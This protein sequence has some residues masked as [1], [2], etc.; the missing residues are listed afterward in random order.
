VQGRRDVD[1][2]CSRLQELGA[3]PASPGAADAGGELS[4][5]D[6]FLAAVWTEIHLCHVCSRQKL[7]SDPRACAATAGGGGGGGGGR[8]ESELHRAVVCTLL[9]EYRFFPRYPA[10]ELTL[11]GRLLVSMRPV[12][13]GY[14]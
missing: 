7:F 6:A 13:L 4:W 8:A 12:G 10:P 3:T 14:A 9:D 1:A 5:D 11:M 2:L